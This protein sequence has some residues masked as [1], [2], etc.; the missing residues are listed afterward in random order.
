MAFLSMIVKDG[1]S[2]GPTKKGRRCVRRGASSKPADEFYM[3][4]FEGPEDG[5]HGFLARLLHSSERMKDNSDSRVLS[6][7]RHER[8]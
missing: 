8:K 7:M 5:A 4:D 3:L 6:L 2:R 1:Q